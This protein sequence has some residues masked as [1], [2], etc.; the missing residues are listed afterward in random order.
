[1][2]ALGDFVGRGGV[3]LVVGV[4]PDGATGRHPVEF[5]AA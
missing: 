2:N 3:A 4:F 1:M 5:E